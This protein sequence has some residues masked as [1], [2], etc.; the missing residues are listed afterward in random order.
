MCLEHPF[1]KQQL[2]LSCII[3]NK[4]KEKFFCK[5]HDAEDILTKYKKTKSHIQINF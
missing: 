5:T 3:W 1:Q 2:V 4:G